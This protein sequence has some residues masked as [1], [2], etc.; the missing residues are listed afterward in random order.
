M[1]L[2]VVA[3]VGQHASISM[4]MRERLRRAD[5]ACGLHV[6]LISRITAAVCK[7][8]ERCCNAPRTRVLSGAPGTDFAESFRATVSLSWGTHHSFEIT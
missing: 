1:I 3:D 2:V 7:H 4:Y 5:P 6:H 8:A